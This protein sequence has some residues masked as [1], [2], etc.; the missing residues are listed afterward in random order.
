MVVGGGKV[1]GRRKVNVVLVGCGMPKKSMGWYHLTQ[2]LKMKNVNVIAVVE[3]RMTMRGEE[4]RV[5]GP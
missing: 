2:L 4:R 5:M 3:V 1:G